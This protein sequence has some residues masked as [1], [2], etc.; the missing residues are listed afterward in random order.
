MDGNDERQFLIRAAL[1]GIGRG[2]R[3]LFEVEHTEAVDN[4]RQLTSQTKAKPKS[5]NKK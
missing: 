4:I 2:W 1:D 5:D 3:R